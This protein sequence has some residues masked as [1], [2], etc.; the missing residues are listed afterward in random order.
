MRLLRKLDFPCV[1]VGHNNLIA[2]SPDRQLQRFDMLVGQGVGRIIGAF[3]GGAHRSLLQCS[4]IGA[5]P[6]PKRREQEMEEP[7]MP[8]VSR[9]KTVAQLYN[10]MLQNDRNAPIIFGILSLLAPTIEA[11]FSMLAL[12]SLVAGIFAWWAFRNTNPSRELDA[13]FSK[14]TKETGEYFLLR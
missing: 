13:L 4:P 3:I 7:D 12:V 8:G 2:L 6:I 9:A 1:R 11:K 14:H 10:R 5:H